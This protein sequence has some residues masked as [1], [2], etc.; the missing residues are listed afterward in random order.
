MQSGL[1]HPT[2][3][4]DGQAYN[5]HLMM[6]QYYGAGNVTLSLP[7]PGA[8]KDKDAERNIK[9]AADTLVAQLQYQL[10]FHWENRRQSGP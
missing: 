6:R 4:Y 7:P 5:A 8:Q 3:G 2:L 9:R 1:V 10:R